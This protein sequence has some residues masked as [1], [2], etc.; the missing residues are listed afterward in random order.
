VFTRAQ[1]GAT[2]HASQAVDSGDFNVQQGHGT[3]LLPE[4]A[5]A[6]TERAEVGD[7]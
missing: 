3:A 4:L 7:P 2:L 1:R 5:Q 6:G